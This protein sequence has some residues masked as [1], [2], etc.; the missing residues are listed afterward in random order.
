MGYLYVLDFDG[1][2]CDSCGESFFFGF[3]VIY[4]EFLVVVCYLFICVFDL[5]FVLILVYIV[6]QVR[7]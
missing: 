5:C 4:L 7:V 2:L 6:G 3:K 1:V